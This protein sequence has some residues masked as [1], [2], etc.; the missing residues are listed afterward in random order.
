MR[1]GKLELQLPR[2]TETLWGV[3]I[4]EQEKDRK[5]HGRTVTPCFGG[6]GEAGV[7]M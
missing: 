3:K 7:E 4:D 5:I 6:Q 2:V 1:Q